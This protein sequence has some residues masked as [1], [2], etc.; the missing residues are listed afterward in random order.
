MVSNQKTK[1][2]A[3][4]GVHLMN[5]AKERIPTGHRLRPRIPRK[6]KRGEEEKSRLIKIKYYVS[7]QG[8]TSGK[9]F[10]RRNPGHLGAE[11][12]GEKAAPARRPS[13]KPRPEALTPKKFSA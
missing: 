5:S 12:T 1:L 4:R 8:R 10:T 2:G 3:R 11:K 6:A 13:F 7:F 9:E